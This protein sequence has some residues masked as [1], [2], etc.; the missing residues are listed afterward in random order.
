MS[1]RAHAYLS[2]ALRLRLGD[3]AGGPALA[4]AP[5]PVDVG[6][7]AATV[8]D[9]LAAPAAAAAAALRRAPVDVLASAPLMREPEIRSG[10]GRTRS[11]PLALTHRRELTRAG[12]IDAYRCLS[13]VVACCTG[14]VWRGERDGT[15]E[16][17]HKPG[18]CAAR[19]ANAPCED[20]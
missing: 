8:P 16:R 6:A 4:A 15:R 13:A 12:R 20:P 14:I 5:V 11:G 17:V 1:A 2:A 19:T 18:P 3:A 7:A 9:G 10:A